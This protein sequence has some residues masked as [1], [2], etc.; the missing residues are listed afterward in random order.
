MEA[1]VLDNLVEKGD[2]NLRYFHCRANQINKRNFI[3][4]L[5][6]KASF[7]VDD[8][9]LIGVVVERYFETMFTSSKPSGFEDL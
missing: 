6:D 7:K 9:S 8:E 2:Q 5:E 1:K 3:P 4:S